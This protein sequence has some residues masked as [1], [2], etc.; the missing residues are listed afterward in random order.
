MSDWVCVWARL[1][2][3]QRRNTLYYA[4]SWSFVSVACLRAEEPFIVAQYS[5]LL[6]GMFY[7]CFTTSLAEYSR[8]L[9]ITGDY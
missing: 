3:P 5:C 8:L 9:E 1:R 4:Y 7:S 6:N 2:L